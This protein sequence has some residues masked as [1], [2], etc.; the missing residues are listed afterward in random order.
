MQQ[1]WANSG[2]GNTKNFEAKIKSH[3]KTQ[4]HLDGRQGNAWI[5]S[6]EQTIATKAT[7][8][9]KSLLRTM[10]I[11]VTLAMMRLAWRWHREHVDNA[12]CHGGNFL[13]VVA[14]QAQFDPVLRRIYFKPRSTCEVPEHD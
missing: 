13:A 5:A 12:D 11:V 7:F 10:N 1:E 14:M 6:N 2:S 8:W 3:E 4:A 9:R